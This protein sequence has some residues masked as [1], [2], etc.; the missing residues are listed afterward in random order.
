MDYI[1]KEEEFINAEVN[2]FDFISGLSVGEISA[3]YEYSLA[4][5]DHNKRKQEGQYF[6]PDDVAQV[7]AKKSLVF[8]KIK[9]GSILVPALGTCHSGLFS[10]KKIKRSF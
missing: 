5:I 10:F 9:Y 1:L 2:D 3:L 6:T 4:Y 7:M 8:P